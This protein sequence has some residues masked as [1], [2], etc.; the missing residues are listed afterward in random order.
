MANDTGFLTKWTPFRL[1]C[2]LH[3]LQ[4]GTLNVGN[5]QQNRVSLL[6]AAITNA[7]GTKTW[8]RWRVGFQSLTSSAGLLINVPAVPGYVPPAGAQTELG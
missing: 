2:T 4:Q 1:A 5:R 3:C 7:S 6:A 8:A